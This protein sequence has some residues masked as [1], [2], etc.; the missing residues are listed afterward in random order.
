MVVSTYHMFL[1]TAALTFALLLMF[2][3]GLLSPLSKN[4]STHTQLYVANVIGITVGVESNELNT[5]TAALTEKEQ[6][7]NNR[8]AALKERELAIGLTESGSRQS[9][10]STYILSSAVFILL[11]LMTLNYALD[12]MRAKR[13]RYAQQ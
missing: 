8:E 3:S 13:F 6:N 5:I 11:V 12:F 7:L 2:D 4:L 9:N 10:L 1:R